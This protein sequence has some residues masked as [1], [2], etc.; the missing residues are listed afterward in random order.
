MALTTNQF[1]TLLAGI[2]ANPTAAAMRTA[3]DAFSL[4]AWCNAESATK[5]WRENVQPQESD[6]AATYT[7]FDTLLAGKREAWGIFLM[8]PRNYSRAK[9]RAWV[10]DVWGAAAANSVSAGI[11]NAAQENATNAQ[12]IIGG[13]AVGAT[14]SVAAALN[15]NYPFDI[16]QDEVNRLIAAD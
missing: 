13:N 2:K 10:I 11:L 1:N 3:G 5:A 12:V 8:F 4:L 15:R 6:E 9:I 7:A 16:S 14:G